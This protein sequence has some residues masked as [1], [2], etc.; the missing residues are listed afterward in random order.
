MKNIE[1]LRAELL[2]I[3]ERIGGGIR[4]N[5]Y[6]TISDRLDGM[7]TPYLEIHSKEYHFIVNERGAEIARKV[8]LSDDE[9]LYWFVECGVAGLATEYSAMNSSPEMEFRYVY[10]RKQYSLMLSIKP[11]WAT[12]KHRE[13][14]EILSGQV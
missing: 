12:R 2:K 1:E 3:G 8:T 5:Y 13:F 10:F 6:F 4:P 14:T 9:I 11:E 7:A